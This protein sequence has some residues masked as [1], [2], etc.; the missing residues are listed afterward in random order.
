MS[1][2]PSKIPSLD[3]FPVTEYAISFSLDRLTPGVDNNRYDVYLSDTF[4]KVSDQFILHTIEDNAM[5]GKGREIAGKGSGAVEKNQFKNSY[6]EVMLS[7]INR[8]KAEREIQVD[9]I[10]RT[11]VAKMLIQG[12]AVCYDKFIATIRLLIREK[13]NSGRFYMDDAVV[14]KA[15]LSEI[16]LNKDPIIRATG[17]I[18]F[19]H[20]NDVDQKELNGIRKSNFGMDSILPED[21]FLNPFLHI[22]KN[23]DYFMIDTYDILPGQRIDDADKYDLLLS[24]IKKHLRSMGRPGL[25]Q[26]G[27]KDHGTGGVVSDKQ[28]DAWI[29]QIGNVDLLFDF[30]STRELYRAQRK[31]G[32]K[33]KELKA[34]RQMA[35][36]Q[37]R[38]LRFFYKKLKSSGVV[39]RICASYEI[40]SVYPEYCPPLV[41]QVILQ[42]MIVPGTR[43]VSINRLKR[44]A[45]INQVPFSARSLKRCQKRIKGLRTS[46]KE[47]YLIRFFKGFFRYH[48]D[49][50]NFKLLER[51]MALVYLVKEENHIRLSR[52]NNTLYEFLLSHESTTEEKPVIS[53][54]ILKVDIRGSTDI[55]H[56]MKEQGLNPA[57]YFSLNMFD[58]ITEIIPEYGAFKVFVEG[59][60]MILGIYERQESPEGW[61]SIARACGLATHI[62]L[63]IQ[64]Y[65]RKNRKYDFPFLEVGIGI[66]FRKGQPTLFFDGDFQI[67]ISS[68]INM[69]DRLSGCS[70]AARKIMDSM[71]TPFNNY[72]FQTASNEDVVATSDDIS[73]RYNVNGIELHPSAF[74][75]LSQE[76]RLKPVECVIPKIQSEKIKFFT[77]IFPTVT[78]RNQWLIIREGIIPNVHEHDLGLIAMTDRKYYEVCTNAAVYDY[79]KKHEF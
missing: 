30:V 20:I 48:R 69:A 57:S 10:A 39:E 21:L 15:E 74:N 67:M 62:L 2:W 37:H 46:Q 55:V 49:F 56:K 71:D 75:K 64:Q 29:K 44:L 12:I 16:L 35:Q 23:N 40:R 7:A 50:E 36:R 18:I 3:Q 70:K 41:P 14:L 28:V 6:R 17:K 73:R 45:K 9:Y 54:T 33:R 52:V 76:I 24:S 47:A 19:E 5:P 72:V 8:A 79:F 51:A 22:E 42:F 63:I 4:C 60:A 26:K 78:G 32:K 53:H 13:E 11:A 58:P 77:G 59:D 65:N 61:Y 25:S 31:Q 38:M 68:A 34:L 43:K 66:T 27:S 1:V